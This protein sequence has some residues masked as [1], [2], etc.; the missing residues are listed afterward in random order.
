M[1]ILRLV[2]WFPVPL[3][4]EHI[5]GPRRGVFSLPSRMLVRLT[6]KHEN[7]D[8]SQTKL[9]RSTA[10]DAAL[11]VGPLHNKVALRRTVLF[12]Q[13]LVLLVSLKQSL[14][15]TAQK[16]CDKYICKDL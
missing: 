9:L 3:S 8:R 12:W 14:S 16:R 13:N 11:P 1:V 2:R 4:R 5:K 6:A 7:Q 10:T 15:K